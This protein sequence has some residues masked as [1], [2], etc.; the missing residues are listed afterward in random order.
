MLHRRWCCFF[1][2]YIK[3]YRPFSSLS[4]RQLPPYH[5]AIP[6]QR[7]APLSS[8]SH[9]N[10]PS[11]PPL[12][13][14]SSTDAPPRPLTLKEE[15]LRLGQLYRPEKKA[16]SIATVALGIST[17]VTMC[18]PAGM[19]KIIDLVTTAGAADQLP[20]VTGRPLSRL[21]NNAYDNVLLSR[22]VG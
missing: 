18:V 19:G 7:V 20:Y 22:P 11:I 15:I 1:Q 4:L 13:T 3:Y 2:P 6:F 12:P 17:T 8:S 5:L 16:L 14:T 9:D 21:N 10:H